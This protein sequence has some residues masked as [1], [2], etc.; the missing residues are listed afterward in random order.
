[1]I[2]QELP[3]SD[4][5]GKDCI[6]NIF[7]EFIR[8]TGNHR[9]SWE[10]SICRSSSLNWVCFMICLGFILLNFWNTVLWIPFSPKA[11]WQ[12]SEEWQSS[13]WS[14]SSEC[15]STVME[16]NLSKSQR[17]VCYIFQLFFKHAPQ[18]LAPF[19]SCQDNAEELLQTLGCHQPPLFIHQFFSPSANQC[20]VKRKSKLRTFPSE[21]LPPV[22]ELGSAKE[23]WGVWRVLLGC[24]KH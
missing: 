16:L 4:P 15:S 14:M 13:F 12:L 9:E 7:V 11:S 1:M 17:N 10:T 24:P 5:L 3:S 6:C 19:V 23:N 22:W 21:L 2:Q 18:E 20:L 8:G